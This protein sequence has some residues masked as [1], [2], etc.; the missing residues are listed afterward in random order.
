MKEEYVCIKSYPGVKKGSTAKILN[1]STWFSIT[2]NGSFLFNVVK[3]YFQPEFWELIKKPLFTTE[4][5]VEVFHGDRLWL[6]NK[7]YEYYSF[8]SD[9]QNVGKM[10]FSTKEAAKDWIELNKPKYSMQDILNTRMSSG[11]VISNT[12]IITYIDLNK[13]KK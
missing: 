11:D 3:S 10:I 6:V 9:C 7:N 5:G 1:D 4:D 12:T 2:D 8:Y 13:L